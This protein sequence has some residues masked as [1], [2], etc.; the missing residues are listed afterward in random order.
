M[1]T[2][3]RT[4]KV[5]ST[6]KPTY[7]FTERER[8]AYVEWQKPDASAPAGWV[9]GHEAG[10]IGL[11]VLQD[12]RTHYNSHVAMHADEA[13]AERKKRLKVG[14]MSSPLLLALTFAA[15]EVIDVN[16]ET[17]DD[18]TQE[19][20]V[21][22]LD[23]VESCWLDPE[24]AKRWD[25][26]ATPEGDVMDVAALVR[27]V[28]RVSAEVLARRG[29]EPE[30]LDERYRIQFNMG[31]RDAADHTLEVLRSKGALGT[32]R[33]T[34]GVVHIVDRAGYERLMRGLGRPYYCH[35]PYCAGEASHYGWEELE[36][37]TEDGKLGVVVRRQERRDGTWVTAIAVC[38][39]PNGITEML[40]K[41]DEER[42]YVVVESEVAA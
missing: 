16:G 26:A 6:I 41:I 31:G 39:R 25:V 34:K 7:K 27:D 3:K 4:A 38:G 28:R 30:S 2:K 15:A 8:A 10:T 24:P 42:H 21:E 12:A 23:A 33:V 22:V 18:D 1:K 40:A 5:P 37:Y 11:Q 19:K 9:T 14:K 20:I 32:L 35:D 13:V 17:M 29:G 36:E